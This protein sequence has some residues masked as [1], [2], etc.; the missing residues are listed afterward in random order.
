MLFEQYSDQVANVQAL[1]KKIGT[2]GTDYAQS[3]ILTLSSGILVK[4]AV[5][6]AGTQQYICMEKGEGLTS[7]PTILVQPLRTTQRFKV[8]STATIA[9]S[10]IGAV[11]TLTT[12]ATAITGTE[13]AGVFQIDET[14][15]VTTTSE[16]IGHFVNTLS[17]VL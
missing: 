10:L 8:T 14:D 7:V 12:A 2:N 16:V 9:K 17:D 4:A 6:S 15:G 5:T 1:E 3:E 13:T 11:V